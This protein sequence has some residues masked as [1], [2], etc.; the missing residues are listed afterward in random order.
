MVMSNHGNNGN[1][2]NENGNNKD[3][4]KSKDKNNNGNGNHNN[5]NGNGPSQ[6]PLIEKTQAGRYDLPVL[7]K[8]VKV[9]I[10]FA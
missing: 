5:G 7:F 6:Q 9:W 4:N 8:S 1:Q 10:G 3:K 2:G